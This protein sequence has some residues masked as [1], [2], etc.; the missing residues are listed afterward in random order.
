MEVPDELRTEPELER[1]ETPSL[2]VT[3]ERVPP[4]TALLRLLPLTLDLLLLEA[5]TDDRPP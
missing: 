3:E 5:L 2:R 1:V 4:L